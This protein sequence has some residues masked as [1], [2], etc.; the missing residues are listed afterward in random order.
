MDMDRLQTPSIDI[1]DTSRQPSQNLESVKQIREAWAKW[2]SEE[3][4]YGGIKARFLRHELEGAALMHSF[5]Q[6]AIKLSR[7]LIEQIYYNEKRAS[8]SLE[9]EEIRGSL[10]HEKESLLVYSCNGITFFVPKSE[11]LDHDNDHV[12]NSGHIE[13]VY[14]LF[15][16]EIRMASHLLMS[17]E[18]LRQSKKDVD[19]L[20]IPSQCV[21]EWMGYRIYARET[22]ASFG[23]EKLEESIFSRTLKLTR[24]QNERK[25][26][27]LP[28]KN[29]ELILHLLNPQ[30]L[31]YYPTCTSFE[32]NAFTEFR[33]H[34]RPE[35]IH[36][37][38]FLFSPDFSRSH[39]GITKQ[40]HNRVIDCAYD[41]CRCQL[42]T[43]LPAFMQI[44]EFQVSSGR[45]YDSP[46][47]E[48][49]LHQHGFNIRWLGYCYDLCTTRLTRRLILTEMLARASKIPFR[50]G[51]RDF[52]VKWKK[53]QEE[54]EEK[55]ILIPN[56][57]VKS[58]YNIF[59]HLA[60]NMM[61]IE[62]R[63]FWENKV[64][65]VLRAKFNPNGP[66]ITFDDIWSN[67][68]IHTPQLMSTIHFHLHYLLPKVKS[69]YRA[70]IFRDYN[71]GSMNLESKFWNVRRK[72]L[73]LEACGDATH[74][75]KS[76]RANLMLDG[77]ML[78]KLLIRS[79][80]E[81]SEKRWYQTMSTQ[82][83]DVTREESPQWYTAYSKSQAMALL[84]MQRLIK[85]EEEE[86]NHAKHVLSIEDVA[87]SKEN[88]KEK[89][90][91]TALIPYADVQA[92][93][94]LWLG[95][96]GLERS[97]FEWLE[98]RMSIERQEFSR[99]S[100]HLDRG[101]RSIQEAFGH[102]SIIYAR[103]RHYQG[104]VLSKSDNF[105]DIIA[106]AFEIATKVYEKNSLYIQSTKDTLHR[107]AK[108]LEKRGNR[109]NASVLQVK[110][111]WFAQKSY[112]V[113]NHG[114][115]L[116]FRL[117]TCTHVALLGQSLGYSHECIYYLHKALK[118]MLKIGVEQRRS[119]WA[120]SWMI[121]TAALFKEIF[122]FVFSEHQK[123]LQWIQDEAVNR[124]D[125]YFR[126][127]DWKVNPKLL[128][129]SIE[130]QLLTYTIRT[131][132]KLQ[133]STRSII[134][135]QNLAQVVT[136]ELMT[137][138]T[139]NKRPD[140]DLSDMKE[141]IIA[142]PSQIL[143]EK[144]VS[145]RPVRDAEM[146]K[147]QSRNLSNCTKND[148]T[149]TGV[150]EAAAIFYLLW[151]MTD[152]RDITLD[153]DYTLEIKTAASTSLNWKA[154]YK[155][156]LETYS[157]GSDSFSCT[158]DATQ[159]LLQD[160]IQPQTFTTCM[161]SPKANCADSTCETDSDHLELNCKEVEE[162]KLLSLFG[163][164]WALSLGRLDIRNLRSHKD[165]SFYH[166]IDKD[167]LSPSTLDLDTVQEENLIYKRARNSAT[168]GTENLK[169]Q[170]RREKNLA[171]VR[172]FRKRKNKKIE[173]M[174]CNLKNME[175]ENVELRMRLK[176]GR[177]AIRKEQEDTRAIKE[178]MQ[179][180]L[181]RN[182]PEKEI[183]TFLNM[184]R[185]SYTDFGPDRREKLKFHISKI[186]DLLLP[187][188]V[189]KLCLSVVEQGKDICTETNEKKTS[190]PPTPRS[191]STSDAISSCCYDSAATNTLWSVLAKELEISEN[192][193]DQILERRNAIAH[194]RDDLHYT[195]QVLVRLERV[196]EE[197]NTTLAAQ[198]KQIQHVLTPSQI[199]KF[200]IWVKENPA[201]MYMLDK[202]VGTTL[203]PISK[204]DVN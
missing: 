153:D 184:Y 139:L 1:P 159:D 47:L 107:L 158:P 10:T 13:E 72:L 154:D 149:F 193:E 156:H 71:E 190:R 74:Q 73:L 11:M 97:Q 191:T 44:L 40:R 102:D 202:L 70:T 194:I 9:Y 124:L 186:R 185:I 179:E 3:N 19:M 36:R 51:L 84:E 103:C 123:V 151:G 129:H 147:Q 4:C 178:Q 200:I 192:Q 24:D 108:V 187:T 20:F 81:P 56:E 144:Y 183:A 41:I 75:Y 52:I 58:F 61:K 148:G 85:V 137:L 50:K 68:I 30:V 83:L 119:D 152:R 138:Q 98:A 105:L 96:N 69:L 204:F 88:G 94:T 164:N 182:A 121:L 92:N 133:K 173:E 128:H 132:V 106:D 160:Q 146:L 122:R 80:S 32:V 55:Y 169:L 125:G 136:E 8:L 100:H 90:V 161:T 28:L 31:C 180:M 113:A 166:L 177:E 22:V 91:E 39:V 198:I 53:Q 21:V 23:E 203:E 63:R 65:P 89:Q 145:I 59:L 114:S 78:S 201:F 199:T 196:I 42:D 66:A 38:G 67:A 7:T 174:E 87:I 162:E 26:Q 76:I 60:S 130:M 157:C 134:H 45:V 197:K 35:L 29:N 165:R 34:F 37:L 77:Y 95:E 175:N 110:A 127:S 135:V 111:Y 15:D 46:S 25:A 176:I 117:R 143:N 142:G 131:F 57:P 2:Q 140:S 126:D 43:A 171:S 54:T 14:K 195:L 27:L 172:E 16:S 118:T 64:L 170:V 112:K 79:T 109:E 104:V 62:S 168:E 155:D 82:L 115:D 12:A 18:N 189:T 188:Q 150:A 116:N 167:L 141:R 33:N 6:I 101:I 181:K 120:M 48:N 49:T 93:C 86:E 99:A 163:A 17:Q 5:Q